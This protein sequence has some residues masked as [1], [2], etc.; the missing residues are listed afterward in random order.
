MTMQQA[1]LLILGDSFS[2]DWRQDYPNS[3]GW[4]T[5]LEES[6]S[7]TNLSQCGCSEYRIARQL[8]TVDPADF[9]YVVV[10]HTSPYRLYAPHHP[11]YDCNSMHRHCDF[12][13]S[14][15]EAHHELY[16]ELLCVKEYFETFFD[17]E[18]AK[19]QHR[20]TIEHIERTLTEYAIPV[21]HIAHIDWQELYTPQ[22]FRC[23][24]DIWQKERGT[25]NHY[26][27]RGNKTV[28]QDIVD[29]FNK[30]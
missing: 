6:F 9:D 1:R 23:Y 16:P 30:H 12:L 17:L 27:D 5:L 13:Y 28:A 11:A 10:S 8:E 29:Y 4:P 14:D 3:K 20:L 22:F 19:F 15:V 18:H 24:S 7:V 21:L 26:T 25:I 2:A